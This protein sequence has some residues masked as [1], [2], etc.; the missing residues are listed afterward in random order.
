MMMKKIYLKIMNISIMKKVLIAFIL[1]ALIFSMPVLAEELPKQKVLPDNPLYPIKILSEKIQVWLTFDPE[2]K[3]AI[4]L[5]QAQTRL[6]ELNETIAIGKLKYVEKLKKDYEDAVNET[7]RMVNRS[8]ALGKNVTALAEHVANVTYKHILVLERILEKAPEQAKSAIEHAINVSIKGHETAVE[9]IL[10]RLNKT[11][12]EVKMFNCTVDADCRHLF[13]PQAIGMD[14]PL[15]EEGKCECG[16]KWEITN[17]TEWKERFREEWT[18]V[19]QKRIEII[20]ERFIISSS[21]IV[22]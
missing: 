20:K 21:P 12:E 1:S 19:T 16:G 9:R 6:A 18:N 14:T 22:E 2:K 15:C 3:V 13:C 5:S 4:R 17:K 7:E 11:A 8:V 10:T